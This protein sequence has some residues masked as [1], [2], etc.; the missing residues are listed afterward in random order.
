MISKT[1]VRIPLYQKAIYDWLYG[2]KKVSKF[3][4]Q[5]WLLDL[6]TLGT[7]R[8]IQ[9]SLLKEIKP[10]RRVL[11][12]GVALGNQMEKIIETLGPDGRYDIM[13]VNKL[14]LDR[15]NEKYKYLYPNMKFILQDASEPIQGRYDII[16]CSMLLH[17][18][19]SS[20]K[21]KIINNI[22]DA[23]DTKNKA[24]FIDYHQP[25][26]RHPLRYVVRMVNRLYQP[27][28]EKLWD[29]EIHSLAENKTQFIWRKTTFFGRMYQKVIVT[30]K[31]PS[32]RRVTSI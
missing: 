27:F 14:Q 29:R 30:K 21:S 11:Q 18:V 10:R 26:Y 25:L 7:S 15:V 13:D 2:S 28:A 8:T 24:I 32:Y 20:T 1:K 6:L 16:I 23:L 4:D 5:Q 3:F 9:N 22:L 17:E 19:P 31:A 12:L